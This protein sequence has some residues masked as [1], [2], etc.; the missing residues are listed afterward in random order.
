ME[1]PEEKSVISGLPAVNHFIGVGL[2]HPVVDAVVLA[3]FGTARLG[4]PLCADTP[5]RCQQRGNR[6]AEREDAK[7]HR[8]ERPA[9]ARGLFRQHLAAEETCGVN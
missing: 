4:D 8:G 7:A 9:S 6:Q 3:L 1:V 2:V 5:V